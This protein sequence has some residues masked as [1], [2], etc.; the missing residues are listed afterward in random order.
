[1]IS[2]ATG[3][4]AVIMVGLVKLGNEKG[5]QLGLGDD[6]GL[7]YL[8]AAVILMGMIQIGCGVLKLGRFIRLV[9]RASN[10]RI[11]KWIGD[12]H[13]PGTISHVYH[14]SNSGEHTV[15]DR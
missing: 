10:V 5:V 4:L 3:A 13:F 1:M 11:C 14:Q 12:C 8:F 15:V 7:Q 9:T 6:M 2:G